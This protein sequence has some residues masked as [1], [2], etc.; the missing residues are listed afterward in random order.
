MVDGHPLPLEDVQHGSRLA[1]GMVISVAGV[2]SLQDFEHR[3]EEHG[4]VAVPARPGVAPKDDERLPFR[5]WFA[6]CLF[7]GA[8]ITLVNYSR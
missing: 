7:H 2:Q 1:I 8:R 3:R 6:D 4:L 5:N